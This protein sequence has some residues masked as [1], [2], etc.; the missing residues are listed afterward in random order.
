MDMRTTIS[1]QISR[2]TSALQS[3]S[4]A[5]AKYQAQITSSVRLQKAS[6]GAADYV[7]LIDYQARDARLQNFKGS[8]NSATLSLNNGVNSLTEASDILTK[9]HDLGLDGA[10]AATDD[11]AAGALATEVDSLIGRFVDVANAK[12]GDS[13]LFSG[14]ATSTP[15]F[16]VTATDPS[17]N[18]TAVSYQ[19]SDDPSK[20]S[21]GQNYTVD[22]NY[23]GNQV[24][25][26]SSGDAFKA[27][28]TLRDNL[29]NPN[30]SQSDRATAINQSLSQIES[31]RGNIQTAMGQQASSLENLDA[32]N[33]RIDD[34]SVNNKEQIGN[35]QNTD[36]A[37][38]AVKL[39]EQ[40]NAFQASLLVTSKIFDASL[41]DFVK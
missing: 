3:Q 40:T 21:V 24:F 36:Y 12:S 2:A 8:I 5:V 1:T 13:Y 34:V 6:D 27:L 26:S 7:S 18:P 31:I 10:N 9:A 41:M 33:T 28:M 15:P 14:A 37:E 30:L 16:V 22:T 32:V 4:A 20:G 17:G 19:G 35:L 25:Q 29:R 39:Q 38:A 11:Q 23:P